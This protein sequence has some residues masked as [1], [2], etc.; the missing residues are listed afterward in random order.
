MRGF[1]KRGTLYAIN[2]WA[3]GEMIFEILTK[4]PAFGN[5]TSFTGY[6]IQEHFPTNLVR[7]ANVSQ[8]GV[9]FVVL[10]MHPDPDDQKT[11][12]SALP[13][14]WIQSLAPFPVQ[15]TKP[16]RG[17]P[18]P[19][20]TAPR[21]TK[22][23]ASRTTQPSPL[24]KYTHVSHASTARES[25]EAGQDPTSLTYLEQRQLNHKPKPRTGLRPR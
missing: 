13:D 7:T 24:Q 20:P 25:A 5:P 22:D 8:L 16:D 19:F 1:S 18:Q 10:L 2:I 14:I 11:A 4:E 12:A 3:L 9:N 23:Y 21:L 15:S 6:K 17:E